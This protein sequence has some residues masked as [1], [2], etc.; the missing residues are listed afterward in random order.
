VNGKDYEQTLMLKRH[1]AK[2]DK[3]ELIMLE[4]LLIRTKIQSS[5]IAK[6][7]KHL[8]KK[9]ILKNE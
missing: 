9:M 1:E 7:I 2:N 3:K 4:K 6:K 8:Q 5:D